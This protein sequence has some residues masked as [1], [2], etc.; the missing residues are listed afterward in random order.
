MTRYALSRREPLLAQLE[1]FLDL[2]EGGPD[3][4]DRHARRGR[5]GSS[6]RPRPSSP[7]PR[8]A[9]PCRRHV[10][11]RHDALMRVVVVALGKIGLPLA[12]AGRA[13]GTPGRR[14]RHR[15]ATSSRSSTPAARR[16]RARSG[17]DEALAELV[18][19]GTAAR[20]GRHHGR[21]R[22]RRRPR[23][24][25]A[26]ADRRRATRDPTGGSSTP[27][28]A[29]IGRGLTPGTTVSVETTLPVGTTRSRIAPALAAASGLRAE[30]DFFTV[31]SP[32]RVYS[33]RI[34]RDLADYPKLV[35][36]LSDA[37]ERSRL[38]A[39]RVVPR[40]AEIWPMGGAEAAELAKLAETTYRD[41]NIAF[42]NELAR[43]A[44]GAGID[45]DRVIDAS[46]SQPFSH[47]HRPG[48]AVGGHCIPVYPRFYLDG[49]PTAATPAAGRAVNEAM[50]AYAVARLA[51]AR[52]RP[53][54]RPRADPRRRLPRRRQGDRVQRRVRGPRRTAAPRARCRS[55]PTR[56]TRPRS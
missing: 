50:P 11:G 13:G 37:G 45:V 33:G 49:D 41:V 6:L 18:A 29:D 5:S 53:A 15:R 20:P 17:L 34:F 35:G 42:A 56:S 22:R 36:G 1:A 28:V 51:A 55:P 2:L 7:A 9:R 23:D 52:W 44:D 3:A 31:F 27:C 43:F 21:R 10:A 48:I 4:R 14:L 12:V 47:I 30:Q 19:D 40:R 54:R 32:E 25:G 46:N 38:R 26:A 24:R 8:P 39:L 16:S